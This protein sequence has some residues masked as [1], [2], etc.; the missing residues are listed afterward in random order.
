MIIRSVEELREVIH[1]RNVLLKFDAGGTTVDILLTHKKAVEIFE[2]AT[3]N[4]RSVRVVQANG[5]ASLDVDTRGLMR[6][7]LG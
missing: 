5:S 1:W 6:R 3:S 2:A 4:G 7:L